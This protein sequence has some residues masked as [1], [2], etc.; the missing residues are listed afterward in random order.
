MVSIMLNKTIIYNTS[1]DKKQ[2]IFKVDLTRNCKKHTNSTDIGK[3]V[4]K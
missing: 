1:I 2:I 4:Y 3:E